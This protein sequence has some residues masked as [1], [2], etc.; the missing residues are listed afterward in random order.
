M[1][2]SLSL[3]S[4]GL[5]LPLLAAALCRS[6]AHVVCARRGPGAGRPGAGSNELPPAAQFEPTLTEESV[7]RRIFPEPQSNS[8]PEP[9]APRIPHHLNYELPL[10]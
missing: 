1:T 4:R 2:E 5:S 9:A 6:V 7:L 3:G 10:L 8:H